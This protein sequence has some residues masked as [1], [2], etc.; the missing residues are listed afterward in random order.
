MYTQILQ[1]DDS[2]HKTARV[3]R[4]IPGYFED[5]WH[6]NEAAP[7]LRL[8]GTGGVNERT[9]ATPRRTFEGPSA[10]FWR[11]RGRYEAA[12][13]ALFSFAGERDKGDINMIM[14]GT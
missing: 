4:G 1:V 13:T 3:R 10:A 11:L 8:A 12:V 2:N 5:A 14:N 7:V 6:F 9:A